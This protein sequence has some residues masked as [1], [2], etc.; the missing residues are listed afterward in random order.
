MLQS[1]KQNIATIICFAFLFKLISVNVGVVSSIETKSVCDSY[2]QLSSNIK[3]RIYNSTV[4]SSFKNTSDSVSELLEEDID[5]ED[6]FK[7]SSFALI[8]FFCYRID[9]VSKDG[10]TKLCAFNKYFLFKSS[11]R[12]IEY[13]VFRI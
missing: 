1:L 2:L 10:L 4:I 3:D 11:N 5:E 13:R 12:Y 7:I 8:L 6:L 9:K